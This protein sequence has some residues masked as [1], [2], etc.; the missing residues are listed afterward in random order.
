MLA[1]LRFSVRREVTEKVGTT[2]FL[3]IIELP[4]LIIYFQYKFMFL[5]SKYLIKN[6]NRNAKEGSKLTIKTPE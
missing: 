4:L 2:S 3:S 6:N 5:T 1:S